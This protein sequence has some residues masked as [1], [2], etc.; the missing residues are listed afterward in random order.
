MFRGNVRRWINGGF[1]DGVFFWLKYLF[2][3]VGFML[4]FKLLWFVLVDIDIDWMLEVVVVVV[5]L[6]L[7]GEI[8][9]FVCKV[10]WDGV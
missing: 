9:F 5:D 3:F 6:D 7:D 4:L 10:C 1:G 8:E 2:V